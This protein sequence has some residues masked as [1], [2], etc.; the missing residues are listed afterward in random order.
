[1]KEKDIKK[2]S[3]DEIADLADQGGDISGHFTNNGTMKYPVKRVNV[4]FTIPMVQELDSL[5]A[6][7]NISRQAVIKSLLRQALDL[8]YS[9]TKKAS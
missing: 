8:H 5:A 9:A 2:L 1:M 4:D 7:M 6:E 3:A